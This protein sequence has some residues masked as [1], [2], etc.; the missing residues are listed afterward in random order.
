MK[1][2]RWVYYVEENVRIKR[3]DWASQVASHREVTE[4][5]HKFHLSAGKALCRGN[6]FVP[7]RCG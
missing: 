5:S 3:D 4:L 6:G 2:V 7:D 1:T